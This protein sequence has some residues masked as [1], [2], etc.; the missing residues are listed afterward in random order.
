M[1]DSNSQIKESYD[2]VIVGGGIHGACAA[3]YAAE[4]GL[5]TLLLERGDFAEA[6]S[7]RSSK[8]AHGGLRYL[9][10][11]D[12]EQVFEGIKAREN[13]FDTAGNLVRPESF[14]IPVPRGA[15]FFKFKLGIGLFLYDLMVKNKARKHRWLPRNKLTFEGFNSNRQDLEGCFVYTDGLMSDARL[16]I[17]NLLLA[18]GKGAAWRN[19]AEVTSV[20]PERDGM[21]AVVWK[22]KLTSSE[23]SVKAKVVLN[24]AGPWVADLCKSSNQEK[25]PQVKFSRGIHL[26]FPYAWKGPSLFLPMPGKSRYYFVWPHPAGTMVG[27]TER[28]VNSA[29]ADPSPWKDEIEEV[30]GRIQKDLSN[31]GLATT[32]PHYC[33]AG[34]RTIA[35]RGTTQGTARLSRK[36]IWIDESGMLTLVGGKYT[37]ASWTSLE[38][39]NL[40]LKKLS[41]NVLPHTVSNIP[42]PGS[43]T[44]QNRTELEVALTGAGYSVAAVERLVRRLGARASRVMAFQDGKVELSP[45]VTVGEVRLSI[46][47][48]N[49]RTVEDIM[50]RRLE[51]EYLEGH[52]LEVVDRIG[53]IVREMI[54]ESSD[55]DGQVARYKERMDSIRS[56]LSVARS[57]GGHS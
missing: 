18:G 22:D 53:D 2:V 42:L 5:S 25:I 3:R 20:S 45:G 8:M 27:T 34:V 10:M 12:F 1:K 31:T 6:T 21:R 54:P 30:M 50:R 49:A 16:V 40:V 36:H 19:Y 15:W 35:L 48:E 17:E 24:C 28:E 33:F 23:F 38:G 39:V 4:A 43:M 11:F 44:E 13:L 56:L 57:S 37:T 55:V 32:P 7:S 46:V 26:L 14:L 47:E 52:G 51:L 29:E 41:R 9:E